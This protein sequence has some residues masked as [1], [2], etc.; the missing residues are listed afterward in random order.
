MNAKAAAMIAMLISAPVQ[1]SSSAYA[2]NTISFM[3]S[4]PEWGHSARIGASTATGQ[5]ASQG[6][7]WSVYTSGSYEIRT[8]KDGNAFKTITTNNG[9][10][11]D[12]STYRYRLSR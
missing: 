9:Q 2:E 1:F 11:T 7:L 12:T 8:Y 6:T 4:I 10:V 5:S 3:D